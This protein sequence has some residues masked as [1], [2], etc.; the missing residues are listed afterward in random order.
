MLGLANLLETSK[1]ANDSLGGTL[2]GLY[3]QI[4]ASN[5]FVNN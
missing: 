2:F 4:T 3:W 5:A 1:E